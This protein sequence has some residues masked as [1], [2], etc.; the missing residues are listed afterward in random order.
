MK[1]RT[2]AVAIAALGLTCSV[3][4]AQTKWDLPAA[5][6]PGNFHSENLVQFAGDVDKAIAAGADGKG[7]AQL[8]LALAPRS[9]PAE[10]TRT[11]E[12]YSEIMGADLKS[13]LQLQLQATLDVYQ[14]PLV[15]RIL[16]VDGPHVLG[17][18]HWTQEHS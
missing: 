6:P 12:I 7:S 14:D 15:F 10:L 5:Y 16:M 1:S 13:H 18:D 17:K 11:V 3:A 9:K 2:L 8:V 4:I